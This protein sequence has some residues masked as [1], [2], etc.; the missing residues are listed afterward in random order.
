MSQTKGGRI[1]GLQIDPTQ[2]RQSRNENPQ[3]LWPAAVSRRPLLDSGRDNLVA[4]V[5]RLFGQQLVARRDS[6][7]LEFYYHRISAVKQYKAVYG[8]ANQKI[9]RIPQSLLSTNRWPKSLRTL[10][11]GLQT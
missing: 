10:G 9:F 8:A 6:G 4:R 7:E 2:T 3:A 1:P 5:L 11:T